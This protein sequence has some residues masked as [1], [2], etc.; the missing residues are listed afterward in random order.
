M[1]T[2]TLEP[3]RFG[4]TTTGSGDG[5]RGVAAGPRVSAAITVQR[6]VGS[7]RARHTVFAIA[8]SI[9]RALIR[10]PGPVYGI[11]ITSRSPCTAPSSP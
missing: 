11:P 4:L 7:R 3:S 1:E 6:G 8:L 10:I 2:P 5:N 9:A